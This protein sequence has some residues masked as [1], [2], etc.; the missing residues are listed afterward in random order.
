M[1]KSKTIYV[2]SKNGKQKPAKLAG[3]N[4]ILGGKYNLIFHKIIILF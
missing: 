3:Q 1:I 4:I 2:F